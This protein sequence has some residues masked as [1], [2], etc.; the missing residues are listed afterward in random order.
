MDAFLGKV[1]EIKSAMVNEVN[2]L[3]ETALLVAAREGYLDVAEELLKHTTK[4]GLSIKN[5]FGFD[6]LHIAANQGH[7]GN[8]IM[9]SR[10]KYALDGEQIEVETWP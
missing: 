10:T 5:R 6:A 3:G 7:A 2:E 8:L 9:T 4:E 1:E